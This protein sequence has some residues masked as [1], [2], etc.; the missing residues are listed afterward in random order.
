MVS[1]DVGLAVAIWGWVEGAPCVCQL[2]NCVFATWGVGEREMI[3]ME[4]LEVALLCGDLNFAW[5]V[6]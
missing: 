2:C 6:L 4:C 1:Q 5:S 3:V